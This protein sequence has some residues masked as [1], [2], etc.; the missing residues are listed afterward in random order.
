ML[1][2]E[3]EGDLNLIPYVDD[4]GIWSRVNSDPLI[5]FTDL[6]SRHILIGEEKGQATG[7]RVRGQAK[8]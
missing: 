2:L 6:E 7:I 3:R 5:G 8:S 1:N 4:E